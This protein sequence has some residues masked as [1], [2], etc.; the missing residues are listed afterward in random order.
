MHQE[1]SVSGTL[2]RRSTCSS[3]S[4]PQFQARSR[5][6]HGQRIARGWLLLG[7]DERSEY[8]GGG[9]LMH[10]PEI[11]RASLNST[12]TQLLQVSHWLRPTVHKSVVC[13]RY[14]FIF[15]ISWL[16]LFLKELLSLAWCN[17]F[18]YD[19][20]RVLSSVWIWFTVHGGKKG[21]V[22]Y[23]SQ[24][25]ATVCVPFYRFRFGAVFLWDSGSSVGDL[26]GHSKLINSVDIKQNRPY[27]IV[28]GSDDQTGSFFEG[29]PFK[30]KF[31]LSVSYTDNY[32]FFICFFLERG[33]V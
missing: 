31:T 23:L 33:D 8:E 25:P 28:V 26:S 19:I 7:M 1:R 4:T 13:F 29:P 32:I 15:L 21:G 22:L 12:M 10:V 2:P 24:K 30:F 18:V 3:T 14:F 11:K 6:L 5:T 17:G 27:R 20:E 9:Y 16:T